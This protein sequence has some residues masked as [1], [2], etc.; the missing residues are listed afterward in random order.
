MDFEKFG[1]LDVMGIGLPEKNVNQRSYV[2]EG[3]KII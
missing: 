1:D 2:N 3:M